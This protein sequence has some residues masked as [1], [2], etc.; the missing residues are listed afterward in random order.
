[1]SHMK[2][3]IAIV[4]MICAAFLSACSGSRHG[5]L[6][7]PGESVAIRAHL[8]AGKTNIVYFYADW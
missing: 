1:M 8:V 4:L 6:N 3:R 2:N 5:S 7:K